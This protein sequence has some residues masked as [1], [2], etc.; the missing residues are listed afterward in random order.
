[1]SETKEKTEPE[2]FF[3][4]LEDPEYL[5]TLMKEHRVT[6]SEISR[7]TG[8]NYQYVLDSVNKR[9]SKT[10]KSVFWMYFKYGI[11]AI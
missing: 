2:I 7:V 3:E 11:K 8:I 6:V 5:K 9:L 4:K 1:M 10:M